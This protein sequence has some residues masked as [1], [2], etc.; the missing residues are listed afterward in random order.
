MTSRTHDS[1]K[2]N[3]SVVLYTRFTSPLHGP[4]VMGY[5]LQMSLLSGGHNG[6]SGENSVPRVNPTERCNQNVKIQ[7]RVRLGEDH[8]RWAKLIAE[9]TF[10][11]RNRVNA[12]TRKTPTEMVKGCELRAPG[13]HRENP[14]RPPE[15]I[16]EHQAQIH[17]E[18]RVYQI[19]YCNVWVPESK[20][21]PPEL[22]PRMYV[23]VREKPVIGWGEKVLC[24]TGT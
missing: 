23:Y 2:R 24:W 6:E 18:A 11:L 20:R 5:A 9:V 13:A 15:Q 3:V 4:Y 14:S 21:P 19:S 17:E 12:A 8:T 10:C 22:V 1:R 16:V 7:L